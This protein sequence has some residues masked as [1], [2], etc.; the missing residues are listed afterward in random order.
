MSKADEG[1]ELRHYQFDIA[2][3][4]LNCQNDVE[5]TDTIL[6]SFTFLFRMTLVVL[7]SH[8]LDLPKV[9]FMLHY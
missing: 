8:F 4:L 6:K 7:S 9:F 2:D 1:I 5:V 3:T